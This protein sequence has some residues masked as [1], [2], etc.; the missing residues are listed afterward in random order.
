[1]QGVRWAH[2][3]GVY[4]G[5]VSATTVLSIVGPGRSGTTILA[6]ILGE[7]E[8]F[9]TV[10]ELRWIWRR[11]VLERR[12][13]GCGRSS[14]EC[15]VWSRVLAKAVD[16]DDDAR[17]LADDQDRLAGL[18]HRLRV[19]RKAARGS[20][21]WA[22]LDHV[23]EGTA[24][25]VAA[26]AE[27]TGTDVVVDSSKRA[28][29]AA[30]LAGLPDVD[31]YVLHIVR[32]PGAV[33]FSWQ[34]KDKVLRVAGGTRPMATRRLV[35]SLARWTENCVSAEAL[36]RRVPPERWLFVR[37]EDFATDPRA[38]VDRVIAFLGRTADSPFQDAN[39]IVLGPNHTVAGNPNRFRTGP[40]TIALDDEWRR[41]MPLRQRLAVRALC[42]PLLARYGYLL[43]GAAKE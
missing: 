34:R 17:A 16:G 21:G 35:P 30:V 29:D 7:V 24:R 14:D 32:D 12:P 26:I 22:P 6:S 27:V 3:V 42:W 4:F 38:V 18:R 11:S 10:G 5:S 41:R 31:H 13:C 23:R 28:Q 9:M 1:M 15:P 20:T 36:R 2:P 39:S 43:R 8:G 19:L 37:Y 40:V 33:A 25:L